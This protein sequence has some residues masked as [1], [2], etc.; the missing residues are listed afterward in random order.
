M[1]KFDIPYPIAERIVKTYG[2][3]WAMVLEPILADK[4]LA[5]QLPGSPALLAAEVDF[6]IRHEMA[7]KV[8]TLSVTLLVVNLATS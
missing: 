5:E 3:R 2:S 8:V 7:T 1:R 4:S 6:A